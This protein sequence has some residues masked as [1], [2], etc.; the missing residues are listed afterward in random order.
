MR[1]DGTSEFE[2]E[3]L[4]VDPTGDMEAKELEARIVA[5][6]YPGIGAKWCGDG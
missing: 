4:L 6:S 5:H 2:A 3:L 1:G